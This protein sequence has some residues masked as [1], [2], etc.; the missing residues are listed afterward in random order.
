MP[1]YEQAYN[2]W[3]GQL[4]VRPATWWVIAK[5]GVNLLWSKGIM[6][7]LF[8]S[9]IPFLVRAI[10]I[11]LITRFAENAAIMELAKSL[12]I[13]PAFFFNFIDKQFFFLMLMLVF[14]G[15]GL[16]SNDKRL[17][18]LNIYFS[19][20][21]SFWDYLIGKWCI[22]AFFGFLITLL[23][24]LILFLMR[25]ALSQD[26]TFLSKYYWIPFSSLAFTLMTVSLL[27]LMILTLSAISKNGRS[28]SVAFFAILMFT[29]ILR[30]ILSKLTGSGLI[31]L[32]AN[33]KQLGSVLFAQKQ[34]FESSPWLSLVIILSLMALCLWIIM[35]KIKPTEVVA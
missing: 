3:H 35:Q 32:Q 1:I 12:E 25:V 23:P 28:A 14:A 21:V 8:L 27:S 11:F 20:P 30:K 17:K 13:N 26:L 19:K 2:P 5:T 24:S 15:G 18:A 29:E 10:Q 31:S 6:I 9:Y 7:L 16:I 22:L 33:L 4:K 34:I